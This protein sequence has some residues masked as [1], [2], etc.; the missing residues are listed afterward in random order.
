[1]ANRKDK[2][3][4]FYNHKKYS[5]E[6]ELMQLMER[7]NSIPKSA[8]A[9][10]KGKSNHKHRL[11]VKIEKLQKDILVYEQRIEEVKAM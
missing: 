5:L 9:L 1:L 6:A 7:Y 11:K 3:I 4:S 8:I 2:K 10:D